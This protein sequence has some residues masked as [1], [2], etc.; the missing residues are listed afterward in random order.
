[1]RKRRHRTDLRVQFSTTRNGA[2]I[3]QL[4]K[5]PDYSLYQVF[6]SVFKHGWHLNILF[7]DHNQPECAINRSELLVLIMSSLLQ[8]NLQAVDAEVKHISFN[9]LREP[10][11]ST[12]DKLL[13]LRE[14]LS[15]LATGAKD[16]SQCVPT[17]VK[18]F[19]NGLY[20][21]AGKC[22][23]LDFRSPVEKL[24]QIKEDA[25]DL[26]RFLMDSFQL[27]MSSISVIESKNG[28]E[29]NKMSSEQAARGAK[30][31]QLA[32]I[33][34]PLS[35]VTSIFGMNVKEV[36]DSPLSVWVCFVALIIVAAATALVFGWY[37]VRKIH[38]ERKA[39][40]VGGDD[41]IRSVKLAR[42][43]QV[44]EKV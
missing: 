15:D 16:T 19:Y 5:L 12:N 17:S 6:Y 11:M 22:D 14:V 27:L 35:F 10:D 30:L 38:K 29:Q 44:E 37:E 24:C 23:H 43:R 18:E 26:Q 2:V 20:H 21:G 3:S 34:V 42:I 1:M 13:N 9:E 25:A 8:T 41:D 31:T 39:N 40:A 4:L 36:N 7:N 33:Y 32:F 28:T